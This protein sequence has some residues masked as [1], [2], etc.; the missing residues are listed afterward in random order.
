[1][2]RI[3]R[4]QSRDTPTG[5]PVAA[6]TRSATCFPLLSGNQE[7]LV[8]GEDEAP[9]KRARLR[10]IPARRIAN[11]RLG[12]SLNIAA[13]NLLCSGWNPQMS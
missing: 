12:P 9:L 3:A 10:R 11:Q 7:K 2:P 5:R 8:V 4:F 6:L 13:V 1:M